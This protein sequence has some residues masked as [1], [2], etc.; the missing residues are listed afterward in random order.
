VLIFSTAKD[1][2]QIELCY[3]L[4]ANSYITK[5]MAFENLVKTVRCL[6]EYWFDIAKLPLSERLLECLPCEDEPSDQ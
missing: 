3:K 5:P 2:E 4:G 6:S 1:Q